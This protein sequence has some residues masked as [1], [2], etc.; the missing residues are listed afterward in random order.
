M[1]Y[2]LRSPSYFR[3]Q[4]LVQISYGGKAEYTIHLN[5]KLMHT[6]YKYVSHKNGIPT[7]QPTRNHGLEEHL[8]ASTRVRLFMRIED[9]RLSG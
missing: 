1:L 3:N 8:G 5:N 7:S 2:T 9:E 6:K 4:S